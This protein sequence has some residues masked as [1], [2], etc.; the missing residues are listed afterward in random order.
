LTSSFRRV[1]TVAAGPL[2]AI[3]IVV[4]GGTAY[5]TGDGA[6]TGNSQ[7][8][9]VDIRTFMTGLACV[10]S[11]GRFDA[12]N[13]SSGALGKYQIMPRNWPAWAAQYMGNLWAEPTP[14]NQEFVARSRI[15]HLH[16]KHGSWRIVAYWWLTGDGQPDESLWSRKALGY[17]NAVMRVAKRAASPVFASTVPQRCFPVPYRDPKIW[18]EP[19]PR[20]RVTGGAVHVRQ[21]AGFEHPA[22]A[23][24]R[25][26][27]KPAFLDTGF[28]ARGQRWLKVGLR[29]GR[30]GW[31]ASWLVEPL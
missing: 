18:T 16:A 19:P 10:E 11:G 5:A 14:R 25:R 23:V 20:V 17:V 12:V 15:A 6:A 27:Q 22:V 29:D 24:V 1:R 2:I 30:T 3:A 4:A 13:S 7:V 28:D 31:V 9:R 21:A 26:G 8:G